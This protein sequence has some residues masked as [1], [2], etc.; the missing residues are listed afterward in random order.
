MAHAKTSGQRN[1]DAIRDASSAWAIAG[2]FAAIRAWYG[3]I[4]VGNAGRCSLARS[5]HPTRR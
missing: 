1:R 5:A 4:A 2:R 3:S